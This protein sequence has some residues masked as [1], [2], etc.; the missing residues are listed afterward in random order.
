MPDEGTFNEDFIQFVA[1][2]AP[3]F[4]PVGVALLPDG[5]VVAFNGDLPLSNG[6][7][8]SSSPNLAIEL[9]APSLGSSSQGAIGQPVQLDSGSPGA[10]GGAVL[11]K[12]SQGSPVLYFTDSNTT[13]VMSL[14]H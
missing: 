8:P 13:A 12:D 7:L 6:Q 14:G 5:D 2:G 11:S 1:E 9:V 4:T 3:L 10:L